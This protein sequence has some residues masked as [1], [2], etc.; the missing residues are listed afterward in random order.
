[1]PRRLALRQETPAQHEAR[2]QPPKLRHLRLNQP[3]AQRQRWFRQARPPPQ[4]SHQRLR[5][6]PPPVVRSIPPGC[7]LQWR[8]PLTATDLRPPPY[9]QP[10]RQR[11]P[12]LHLLQH[13]PPQH[14]LPL[15]PHRPRQ[16]PQQLRQI[17]LRH[18]QPTPHPLRHLARPTRRHQPLL[19]L[20]LLRQP[21]PPPL[22]PAQHPPGHLA[23]PARRYRQRPRPRHR[24]RQ[25]LPHPLQPARPPR[26][27]QPLRRVVR[28]VSVSGGR[29]CCKL[30]ASSQPP[31]Q[32]ATSSG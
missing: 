21:L 22:R 26:Q 30:W 20:K 3:R 29:H 1:M 6:Q 19:R 15:R 13:R 32:T 18:R 28:P 5:P 25:P 8:A 16:Q 31:G 24:L 11:L 14:T 12:H 17:L 9:S 10:A 27:Y 7:N 4:P 23:R 2:S